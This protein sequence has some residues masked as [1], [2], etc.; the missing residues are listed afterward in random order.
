MKKKV[1]SYDVIKSELF[2]PTR[3]ENKQTKKMCLNGSGCG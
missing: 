1:V 3:G 2:T